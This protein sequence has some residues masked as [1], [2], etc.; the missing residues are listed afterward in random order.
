MTRNMASGYKQG[1]LKRWMCQ[2]TAKIA[3]SASVHFVISWR[4]KALIPDPAL[5]P[6][7]HPFLFKACIKDDNF[8]KLGEHR[9]VHSSAGIKAI[10]IRSLFAPSKDQDAKWDVIMTTISERNQS[11]NWRFWKGW[12][13][14]ATKQV[15]YSY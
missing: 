5:L 10:C 6:S 12:W 15:Y 13:I 11:E 14:I 8:C 2:Q 1:S 9:G 7:P 3:Y 4:L